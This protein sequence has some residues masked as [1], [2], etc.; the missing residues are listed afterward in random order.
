MHKTVVLQFEAVI[1]SAALVTNTVRHGAVLTHF[2]VVV[3]YCAYWP[4]EGVAV[5][6]SVRVVDDALLETVVGCHPLDEYAN[7]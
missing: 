6:R 5:M 7:T 1:L 3:S 2:V 4:V